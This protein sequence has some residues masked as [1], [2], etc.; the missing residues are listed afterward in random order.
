MR[1]NILAADYFLPQPHRSLRHPPQKPHHH[2][3]AATRQRL[4]VVSVDPSIMENLLQT[5]TKIDIPKDLQDIEGTITLDA[6]ID[7]TGHIMQLKI[8]PAP[9]SLSAY[10]IEAVQQWTYRPF[11]MNGRPVQ[12]STRIIVQIKKLDLR[13]SIN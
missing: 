8:S 9:H 5:Q 6:L 12:V 7:E 4:Q 3:S 10:V 1:K 2:P 13:S 11:T